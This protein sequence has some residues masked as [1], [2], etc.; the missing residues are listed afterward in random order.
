MSRE[1]ELVVLVTSQVTSGRL[2][3]NT[4]QLSLFTPVLPHNAFDHKR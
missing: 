1:F 2:G 4:T 3:R